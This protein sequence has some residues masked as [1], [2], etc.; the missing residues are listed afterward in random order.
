MLTRQ[1]LILLYHFQLDLLL[2]V[3]RMDG[4]RENTLFLSYGVKVT[5]DISGCQSL[6]IIGTYLG[7]RFSYVTES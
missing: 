3:S 4:N 7:F 5:S 1:H 6:K 2:P